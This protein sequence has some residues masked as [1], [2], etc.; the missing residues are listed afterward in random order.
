MNQEYNIGYFI[1]MKRDCTQ[2]SQSLST[3][4]NLLS[5]SQARSVAQ[6]HSVA[7]QK[8]ETE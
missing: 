1:Q 7:P 3:L 5:D 8:E 6:D 4:E 2:N